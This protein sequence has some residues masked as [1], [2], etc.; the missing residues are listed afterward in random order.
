[1]KRTPLKRKTPLKRTAIK[2][3]K[4]KA[5]SLRALKRK[6][7]ELLSRAIRL[8][9][10]EA[11]G[12][13]TCVSCKRR[14][15]WKQIQAGHWIDGRF[16]SILFDERGIHPQCSMCN[17]VHNGRKEEYFIF[18]EQK[19]G[20]DVMDEL[21]RQRNDNRTFTPEELESLIVSLRLRID[22]ETLKRG[23]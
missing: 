18:M 19:H 14:M 2:R 12:L 17:V 9:A 10:R 21:R 4:P 5:K 13:V 7:W 23:L 20:R 1:M 15:E 6:A 22:T 3:K 16:N 8:E 11:D